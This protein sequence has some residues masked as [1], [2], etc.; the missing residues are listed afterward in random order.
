MCWSICVGKRGLN[1]MPDNNFEE[2][3][4]ATLNDID[5]IC[6]L[7]SEFYAHNANLQPKYY[8]AAKESGEYPRSTI[9]NADSDI[10]IAL[11]DELIT[12]LIHIRKMNTPPYA[13][14]VAHNYAEIVDLIT[15]TAHRKSGIG[16][17]L[18]DAAKKWAK[19]REL[20]YIELSVLSESIDGQ[21]FYKHKDFNYVSH[22][23]RCML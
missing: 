18:M 11:K 10:I 5:Q 7:Y 17:M 13:A 2:I 22:T 23:M 1:K 16:S 21:R 15:T 9:M 19:M 20:N 3:R 12:G 14:I 4:L 8:K 6:Q